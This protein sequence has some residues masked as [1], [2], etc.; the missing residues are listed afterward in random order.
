MFPGF[1]LSDVT[2]H[3]ARINCLFIQER[4]GNIKGILSTYTRDC[5]RGEQDF[6]SIGIKSPEKFSKK[7]QNNV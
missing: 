2:S 3:D 5:M 1:E 6:I 4:K 7:Q